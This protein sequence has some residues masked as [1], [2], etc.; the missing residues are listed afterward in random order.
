MMVEREELHD[1]LSGVE[2]VALEE[3][4]GSAGVFCHVGEE[5]GAHAADAHGDF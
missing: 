1:G 3:E 4:T 2:V 5:V